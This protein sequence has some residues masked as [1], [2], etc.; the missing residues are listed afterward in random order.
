MS[1]RVYRERMI[2]TEERVGGR[3]FKMIGQKRGLVEL[4]SNQNEDFW[5]SLW[6]FKA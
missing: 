3:K 5:P 6:R 2:E 1:S 4:S